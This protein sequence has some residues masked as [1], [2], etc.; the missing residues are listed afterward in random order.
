MNRSGEMRRFLMETMEGVRSGSMG[1]NE[2]NSIYKLSS[3]INESVYSELKA[4]RVLTEL[5]D[6]VDDFGKLDIGEKT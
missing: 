2:A 5:G 3:Q 1:V 4:I 6:T